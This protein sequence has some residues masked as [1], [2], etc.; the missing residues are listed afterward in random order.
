MAMPEQGGIVTGSHTIDI[1]TNSYNG[2]NLYME[3]KSPSDA[4]DTNPDANLINTTQQ[5]STTNPYTIASL[6]EEAMPY[7]GDTTTLSNNT[8][9]IAMPYGA[10]SDGFSPVTADNNPYKADST[11]SEGQQTLSTTLWASPKYMSDKHVILAARDG[12]NPSTVHP[13]TRTIYYGVRV[14]NPSTIPAGDYQAGIVYTAIANLPPAPT[15]TTI[16]PNTYTI[17]SNDPTTITITGTNLA[18]TYEVW[19]DLDKDTNTSTNQNINPD[20]NEVCTNIQIVSDTKLTCTIPTP[21][22]TLTINPDTYN[23][24]LRTQAND[25][26]TATFTYTTPPAGTVCRNADPNSD[27]QVDIDDNMIPIY[28]DGNTENGEAIW[29]VANPNNPGSWYDYTNKQWANAVTVKA[30]KLADYQKPGTP[31]DNNDVL[32]YWVYIPRYAYEVQRPNAVDRVVAPQNFNIRFETAEDTKKT[33]ASSCNLGIETAGDMWDDGTPNNVESNIKAKDYRTTCVNESGGTITRDYPDNNAELANGHTTWATHPAFTWSDG[34][35]EGTTELNG[36]WIG[37][38]EL[39]GKITEPTV[40]PNSFANVGNYIGEYW[41]SI[42]SMGVKDNNNTGGGSNRTS[43]NKTL[44]NGETINQSI[45]DLKQNSHN[46]TIANSTMLKNDQW[47]AVTYLSASQYGAGVNKVYNNAAGDWYYIDGDGLYQMHRD[48]DGDGVTSCYY[49]KQKDYP[50]TGTQDAAISC[51][52]GDDNQPLPNGPNNSITNVDGEGLSVG[53]T[54]TFERIKDEAGTK[55]TYEANIKVYYGNHTGCGP[56]NPDLNNTNAAGSTTPY[57]SVNGENTINPNYNYS[58]TPNSKY[59]YQGKNGQ[60]ASTTNN[61]YGVYDMAGGAW[62]YVASNM[63]DRNGETASTANLSTAVFKNSA[64]PP[65]VNLLEAGKYGFDLVS[66]SPA[67]EEQ[68]NNRPAWS[69]ANTGTA[70]YPYQYNNDYCTWDSC[71]GQA[72]HETKNYQSV[73]AWNVSWGSDHAPL[74]YRSLSWL[75]R[76]GR[77]GGTSAAG[78]FASFHHAGWGNTGFSSRAALHTY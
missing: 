8:W 55:E 22:S 78:V 75:Q 71:G 61:V 10:Y 53:K 13:E 17:G 51:F 74:P 2:W 25:L 77:V 60:L 37:K 23:L 67:T 72:L 52:I 63:T 43:W 34:T 48:D 38:F 64:K 35:K 1:T 32:G 45:N 73:S 12:Y 15:I 24:Y 3:V 27:C 54:F 66:S 30:D 19:I 7:R 56:G 6:P 58:C 4:G 36:F 49:S 9:G 76:G 46:L 14:D 70:F 41:T 47:G 44:P 5:S 39:T 18:S 33:P 26:A 62:D 69:V 42:A 65:Y 57:Y 40:L 31:I 29:K 28:Y 16:T 68:S 20:P 50:E 11:T 59:S 21:S